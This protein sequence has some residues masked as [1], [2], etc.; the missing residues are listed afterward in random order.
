MAV[1]TWIEEELNVNRQ[2]LE[3]PHVR[4]SLLRIVRCAL[5]S[6]SRLLLLGRHRFLR[7]VLRHG[8]LLDRRAAQASRAEVGPGKT[9]ADAL[10]DGFGA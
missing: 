3:A 4:T 7:F 10:G 9:G 6:N 1:A 2:N 8:P 5:K